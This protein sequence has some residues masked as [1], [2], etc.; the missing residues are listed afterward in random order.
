MLAHNFGLLQERRDFDPALFTPFQK[1]PLVLSAI[2]MALCNIRM[3]RSQ[4]GID[5]PI[6]EPCVV[7]SGWSPRKN[8]H[9]NNVGGGTPP[10]LNDK[11]TSEKVCKTA[12]ITRETLLRRLLL[13][14]VED[15]VGI[16][17]EP[18]WNNVGMTL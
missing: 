14:F 6:I 4:A 5:P 2:V 8:R 10:G 7:H 9:G 18:R 15:N 12:G 1:F 16:M 13:V 17:S 3:P 11:I